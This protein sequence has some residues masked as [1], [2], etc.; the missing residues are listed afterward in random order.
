M[1]SPSL[2]A[3]FM[4][5]SFTL[6]LLSH[7][8][9]LYC[10]IYVQGVRRGREMEEQFSQVES[11]GKT[12]ITHIRMLYNPIDPKF[13]TRQEEKNNNRKDEIAASQFAIAKYILNNPEAIVVHEDV[14]QKMS[15]LTI[16]PESETVK[17]IKSNFD[18]ETFNK[19]FSKL[20]YEQKTLLRD[21]AGAFV[22]YYLGALNTIYPSASP[23]FTEYLHNELAVMGTNYEQVAA[24]ERFFRLTRER[25]AIKFSV[26]AAEESNAKQVILPF[27]KDKI[28]LAV[29]SILDRRKFDFTSVSVTEPRFEEKKGQLGNQHSFWKKTDL[30]TNELKKEKDLKNESEDLDNPPK[31]N[32]TP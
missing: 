4:N 26:E 7:K 29:A 18:R 20:T 16:D 27:G 32:P 9:V 12:L 22:L 28:D 15:D 8:V 25:E 13:L 1:A 21:H 24:R 5:T 23:P 31:K 3:D 2:T 11:D 17:S 14:T 6:P 30:P 10:S 19:D